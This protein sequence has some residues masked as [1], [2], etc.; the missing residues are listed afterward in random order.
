M[1]RL[2]AH[3]LARTDAHAVPAFDLAAAMSDA[4]AATWQYSL[5]CS[6]DSHSRAC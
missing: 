2:R 5:Q 1:P 4:L 6:V 3:C